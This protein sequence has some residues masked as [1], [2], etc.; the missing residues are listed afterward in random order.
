[1]VNI[2]VLND[3][4]TSRSSD[5]N[6]RQ[7]YVVAHFGKQGNDVVGCGLES[8]NHQGEIDRCLQL[9]WRRK[10]DRGRFGQEIKG[11]TIYRAWFVRI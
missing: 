8:K 2:G 11:A 1:M 5:H 3:E 6:E 7:T 4:N 10:L 9:Q